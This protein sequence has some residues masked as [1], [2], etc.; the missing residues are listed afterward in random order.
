MVLSRRSPFFRRGETVLN[1][2]LVELVPSQLCQ[3]GISGTKVI[4]RDLDTGNVQFV[5][6]RGSQIWI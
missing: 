3:A 5:D 6:D 4:E 2:D 1:L